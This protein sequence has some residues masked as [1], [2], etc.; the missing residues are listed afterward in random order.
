MELKDFLF[1]LT[2]GGGAGIVGYWVMDQVAKYRPGLSSEFKRYLS[3]A[4]A[5]G[6][7]MLA[8]YVLVVMAYAPSPESVQAWVEALFSVAAVAVGLSQ[9]IHGRV[10]LRDRVRILP[11]E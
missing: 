3:L 10:D 6:L 2:A 5:A 11:V 8:H 7:A 1:W 4:L 9:A